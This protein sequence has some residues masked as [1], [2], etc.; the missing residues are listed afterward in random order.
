MD[1]ATIKAISDA[2]KP[3]ADIAGKLGSEYFALAVR[4]SLYAGWASLAWAVFAACSHRR[5]CQ[6]E[7]HRVAHTA[8]NHCRGR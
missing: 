4:H 2:L 3:L 5:V 1:S 6:T 7:F 8:R